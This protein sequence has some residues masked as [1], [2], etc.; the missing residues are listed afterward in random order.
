M[1]D[2]ILF[3]DDE[4]A[5]LDGYRR[6]LHKHYQPDT[7]TSGQEALAAI[8]RDGPYAVVISDMR[9]P[10]MDGVKL[11]SEV[12]VIAPDTVRVILTGYADFQ[13]AMD[14]VNNGKV[15]RFLTKPCDGEALRS[16]LAACIEQNR[17]ITS[18]KELLEETLIGCVRALAEILS[19][20]NPAAFSRGA[21]IRKYVLQLVAELNLESGWKYEIAALLSQLGCITLPTEVIDAAFHGLHLTSEQQNVFDKHPGVTRDLLSKI[22]RVQ[23]IGWIVAQQRLAIGSYDSEAPEEQKIGADI[24]RLAVAFDDLKIKNVGDVEARARLKYILRAIPMLI[25][26]LAGLHSD[27]CITDLR[28]VRISDLATGMILQEDVL[29]SS[30]LLIVVRG[31]EITLPLIARLNNFQ[32]QGAIPD[33]VLVLCPSIE[34]A[35]A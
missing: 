3:V 17:L 2:K 25:R 10:G 12:S 26:G 15:F 11:L 20:A 34:N 23:D 5:I 16:T 19:L 8:K 1:A 28:S 6:S 27:A 9:M 21:R 13:S 33:K 31:H 7:A 32:L 30:G 24:L 22:P 35:F 14:A 29:T 4:P 18:E